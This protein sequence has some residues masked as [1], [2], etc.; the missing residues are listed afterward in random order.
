MKTTLITDPVTIK[1][2]KAQGVFSDDAKVYLCDIPYFQEL[3]LVDNGGMVHFAFALNTKD[4]SRLCVKIDKMQPVTWERLNAAYED[5]ANTYD[6]YDPSRLDREIQDGLKVASPARSAFVAI[7]HIKDEQENFV[8]FKRETWGLLER[9]YPLSVSVTNRGEVRYVVDATKART[10][11]Y[12]GPSIQ[13]A[14][15][16][17]TSHKSKQPHLSA[18]FDHLNA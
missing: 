2:D 14:L 15:T 17:Y 8:K 1:N 5:M 9:G 11:L 4:K 3:Y 12:D 16:A 6:V 13:D 18:A 7:R 10:R